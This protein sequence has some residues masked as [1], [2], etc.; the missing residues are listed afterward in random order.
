MVNFMSGPQF[1]SRLPRS[2][3]YLVETIGAAIPA[4]PGDRQDRRPCLLPSPPPAGKAGGRVRPTAEERSCLAEDGTGHAP[5]SGTE[6]CK[7]AVAGALADQGLDAGL[8][9]LQAH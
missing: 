1:A 4:R 8:P 3:C 6:R 2:P 7:A 5:E 9:V